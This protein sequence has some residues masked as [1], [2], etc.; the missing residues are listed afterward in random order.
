MPVKLC[1]FQCLRET[2]PVGML[3]VP[4]GTT[5]G[6]SIDRSSDRSERECHPGC[7]VCDT[8]LPKATAKVSKEARK[9]I[10]LYELQG[11][12]QWGVPTGNVLAVIQRDSEGRIEVS[13]RPSRATPRGE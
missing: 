3:G 12:V 7:V 9:T 11:E 13:E 2:I 6:H 1:V 10:K 5:D 8:R 4:D